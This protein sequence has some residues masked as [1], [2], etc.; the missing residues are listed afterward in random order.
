MILARPRPCPWRASDP[1]V[2]AADPQAVRRRQAE[3]ATMLAR[4]PSKP[5]ITGLYLL[6]A[7]RGPQAVGR[8]VRSVLPLSLDSKMALN[9][10]SISITD[11]PMTW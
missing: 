9:R 4:A 7:V 10:A 3:A 6:E 1:R 2:I 5:L 8:S 11:S